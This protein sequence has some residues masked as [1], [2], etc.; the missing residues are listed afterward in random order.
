MRW[1][2]SVCELYETNLAEDVKRVVISAMEEQHAGLPNAIWADP[3]KKIVWPL[4][5]RVKIRSHYQFNS[6]PIAW[7]SLSGRW[8]LKPGSYADPHKNLG[9]SLWPTR[10]RGWF[11]MELCRSCIA[12]PAANRYLWQWL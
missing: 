2:L 9:P 7:Q 6:K 3:R 12:F 5:V 10:L 4:L 1:A 8:I 11:G